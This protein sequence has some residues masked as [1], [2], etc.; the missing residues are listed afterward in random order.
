MI[1][2][3]PGAPVS[4]GHAC[5]GCPVARREFVRDGLLG[6]AG[7]LASLTIAGP[8]SALP[9]SAISTIRRAGDTRTYPVPSS[10]GVHIDRDEEVILLRWESAVYA[11]SLSCPHQHTALRW[12]DA[13]KRFQCPRH[14]SRYQPDGS[15]ISGRA[16]RSMDRFAV[17]HEE[18]SIVVDLS[19]LYRQDADAAGW[20]AAVVRL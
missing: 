4:G 2:R 20:R 7:V 9:L 3:R 12:S 13:D 8:V 5:D 14:K 18:T 11:F 10:D 15:F 6:M 19:T 1:T 16:T 17:R